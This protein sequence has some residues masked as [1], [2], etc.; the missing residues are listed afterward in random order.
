[1]VE[2]ALQA[3]A[4]LADA[5]RVTVLADFHD[6]NRMP[7][8]ADTRLY[9]V[10]CNLVRNAIDAMPGGGQLTVRTGIV[11]SD[12]IVRIADTGVGLPDKVDNVFEPFY[13]SKPPGKGTG[14]GLAICRE[15]IGQLGGRISAENLRDGGAVFTVRIPVENC[16]AS[17]HADQTYR[18]RT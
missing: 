15:F 13:T 9:Q 2:E 10:C 6:D 16:R 14:L 3:L 7:T 4:H 1:V 11:E 5:N 12:V 17:D 8:L 18:E